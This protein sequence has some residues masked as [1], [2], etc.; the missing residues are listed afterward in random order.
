[1]LKSGGNRGCK[2]IPVWKFGHF[3]AVLCWSKSPEILPKFIQQVEML[4]VF[5]LGWKCATDNKEGMEIFLKDN[6]DSSSKCK[7]GNLL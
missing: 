1:M 6:Q 3:D 7:S 2:K 5:E 4:D